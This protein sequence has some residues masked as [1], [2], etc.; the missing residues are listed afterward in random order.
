MQNRWASTWFIGSVAA[1]L[2]GTLASGADKAEDVAFFEAKIRPVLVQ[3]CYKC[4]SAESQAKKTWK[5]GLLLD[6]REGIRRAENRGLRLCRGMCK[7][8]L[9]I[10][11][12]RQQDFAMPPSGKLP[13]NVIADFE[14]WVRSGAADPRDGKARLDEAIDL[15][16]GRKFWSFQPPK[17]LPPPTVKD[18]TWPRSDI[19]RFIAARLDTA[20]LHPVADAD[21]YS[22]VRRVYFDLIGLPPTPEEVQEFIASI[23]ASPSPRVS[24]STV[25]AET[26]GRG[27]GEKAYEVLVDKLLASPQFGERWGRHWLDVARYAESTGQTPV[28][29]YRYAWR[30]RDYVIDAFNNDKPYDQ[31]VREQVAGDLL[32]S[33]T[34]EQRNERL[35][36]TGFL[37]IG[38]RNLAENNP[39]QYVMENVNEQIETIGQAFLGMSIGCAR[40]HDHK[41]DPIPAKDYYALAGILRSSELMIG[42]AAQR[43]YFGKPSQLLSLEMRE[44]SP[45]FAAHQAF[46]QQEAALTTQMETAIA[47]IGQSE[48]PVASAS[49][50]VGGVRNLTSA[51]LRGVL[52]SRATDKPAGLYLPRGKRSVL[53]WFAG[54]GDSQGIERD[55]R[56]QAG[57]GREQPGI[58][59]SSAKRERADRPNR[60]AQGRV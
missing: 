32:D 59:R 4:H 47:E 22:L 15:E 58:S 51:N 44:S 53:R 39:L 55:Q 5:G 33:D 26:R 52:A 10:K 24:Q 18:A 2:L 31:F 1:S 13:D 34:P 19:D 40:C 60:E 11:A 29:I 17:K 57:F 8:S 38:P 28:G 30:Y 56:S 35:V 48:P 27:D 37:A 54:S 23:P 3:H 25:D 41:F 42:P 20:K 50:K 45:Q 36:A 43:G 16:Q 49:A 12:L 7:A 6:S 21:P 46:L 9:L 14:Q